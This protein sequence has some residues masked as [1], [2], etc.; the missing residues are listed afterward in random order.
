V[1]DEVVLVGPKGKLFS[2]GEMFGPNGKFLP[3]G[4]LCEKDED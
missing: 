2:K 1:N 3:K 4:N